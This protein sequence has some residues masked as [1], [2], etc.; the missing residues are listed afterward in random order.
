MK[1]L[2]S[3]EEFGDRKPTQI[4]QIMQHL[5]DRL[6][7][8]PDNYF[9]HEFFLQRLPARVRIDLASNDSAMDMDKLV[10]MAN[11]VMEVTTQTFAAISNT[12]SNPDNS[13]PRL[14]T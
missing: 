14:L 8:S 9:L 4:L 7:T 3:G 11:K 13:D 1:Q 12:Y 2:I 10:H 5:G 6:S